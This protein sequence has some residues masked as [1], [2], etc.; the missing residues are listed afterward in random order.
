MINY[1]F[2]MSKPSKRNMYLIGISLSLKSLSFGY[3][4]NF[5]LSMV[6][7]LVFMVTLYFFPFLNSTDICCTT[8]CKRILLVSPTNVPRHHL[9]S[10]FN[11]FLKCKFN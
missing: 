5:S 8:S 11:I 6:K 3:S 10:N 7:K 4:L 9:S 1:L 2:Y